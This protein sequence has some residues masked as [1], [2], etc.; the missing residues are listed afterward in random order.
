MTMGLVDAAR[1]IESYGRGP[2][3]TL[4]HISPNESAV[5][6]YLQGGRR[7]NP[8]TGLPEYSMFGNILDTQL[9]HGRTSWPS[10]LMM[11]GEGHV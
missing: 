6:D 3:K 8:S 10:T 11:D 4:A 5:M 7:E 2:D 9:L 1:Q